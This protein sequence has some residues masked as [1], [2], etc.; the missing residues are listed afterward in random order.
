MNVCIVDTIVLY[1]QYT[2][3]QNA[4]TNRKEVRETPVKSIF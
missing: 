3:R 2:R 1:R 4:L